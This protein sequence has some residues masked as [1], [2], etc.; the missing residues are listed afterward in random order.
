[1]KLFGAASGPGGDPGLQTLSIVGMAGTTV[2]A[3][4]NALSGGAKGAAKN[5]VKK[6]LFVIGENMKRVKAFAKAIGAKYYKSRGN[7][8]RDGAAKLLKNNERWIKSE[9]KAGRSPVDIGID[10]SR[11]YRSIPY[12]KESTE[13]IHGK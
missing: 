10:P 8:E 2:D 7:L 11:N 6:G 5:I 13:W 12:H 3:V 1:M 4:Y 9:L